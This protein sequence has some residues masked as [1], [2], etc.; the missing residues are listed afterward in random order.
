MRQQYYV[1]PSDRGILA[2]DVDCLVEAARDLP[3]RRIPLDHIVELDAP[4]GGPGERLT[5]RAMVGHLRLIL[6]ADARAA[7]ENRSDILAV[8]F[9]ADPD[10]DFVGRGPDDLPY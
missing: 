5:W 6:E 9:L 3:R 1:R 7:L 8:Q 4:C 2:W 10:P